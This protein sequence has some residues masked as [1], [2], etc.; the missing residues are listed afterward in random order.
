MIEMMEM[1]LKST[2]EIYVVWQGDE[3]AESRDEREGDVI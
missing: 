2:K 1:G 3:G